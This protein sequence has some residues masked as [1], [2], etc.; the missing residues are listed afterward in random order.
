MA[1]EAVDLFRQFYE[2]GNPY[3]PD[4]KRHRALQPLENAVEDAL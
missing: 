3:A 4:A 1:A 2:R